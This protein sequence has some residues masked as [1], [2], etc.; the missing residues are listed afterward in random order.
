MRIF[1]IFHNLNDFGGA[2]EH[3]TSLAEL[4][5]AEGDDVNVCLIQSVTDENQYAQRLISAGVP[6]YQWPVWLS[7]LSG[8]WDTRETII[9]ALINWLG[10]LISITVFLLKLIGHRPRLGLRAS[11]EG[12]LRTIL[13]SF[14]DQN[15]ERQ[16]F[17]LLLTW[18]YHRNRPDVLHLHSY[19]AGLEFVLK[20]AQAR[21]LPAIYQEH[22]TPDLTARRWYR[23]PTDL[24]NARVVVA[25][26][27]TSAKALQQLCGVTSPIQVVPPIV[28]V[29]VHEPISDRPLGLND[30]V[31]HI[32]TIARLST[33]KGLSDLIKAAERVVVAKPCIQFVVYGEGYLRESLEEEIDSAHLSGNF[34]LAGS[35]THNELPD[36]MRAAD[37]FVLPS[38]TEGFPLTIVEAMAWGLPIVAT[39]VG[40]IPELVEDGVSGL[41]CKPH[42][43][44]D[45][46]ESILTLVNDPVRSRAFGVAAQNAYNSRFKPL[47][48]VA[49]FAKI[50]SKA[51]QKIE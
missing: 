42:D 43:V 6:I 17:L 26:S 41:L 36:I 35:F 25:V 19:G 9:G 5:K 8:D 37:I 15:R 31:V 49:K 21:N 24:N 23:L 30:R 34:C 11:T 1:H 32:L 7:R 29:S 18:Q 48:V 16:L 3:I 28:D 47:D 22:S 4:Q 51:L 39:D 27:E 13:G 12:R 46:A 45:L 20:W 44:N 10:P 40:G 14:F 33:E 38:I 50:Y 2:E